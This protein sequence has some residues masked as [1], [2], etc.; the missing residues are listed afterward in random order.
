MRK[1]G[2]TIKAK[3]T[4]VQ[5]VVV[6]P[7][8][9]KEWLTY[10]SR[11]RKVG[12]VYVDQYASDMSKNMWVF[13][14]DAIVFGVKDGE[15]ILL[16]GQKRLLACVKSGSNFRTLVVKGLPDTVQSSIDQGQ[17]RSAAQ[18]FQLLG[19]SQKRH[20][21]ITAVIR[22]IILGNPTTRTGRLKVSTAEC[23][24]FNEAY[25]WVQKWILSEIPS[26]QSTVS[27]K[28]MSSVMVAVIARARQH[29]PDDCDDFVRE[30]YGERDGYFADLKN[31]P[32]NVFARW[33]G[34]VRVAS[35]I[36]FHIEIYEKMQAALHA[37][38]HRRSITKLNRMKGEVFPDFPGFE[39]EG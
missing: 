32:G 6:T 21:H 30:Y 37:S 19:L 17:I 35:G 4:D 5:V 29:H 8:L 7:S 2:A 13:N 14:G 10:N 33:H 26:K 16:D 1:E 36:G 12:Q 34:R 24:R 39:K 27:G 23:M 20:T 28:V 3:G 25:P 18:Q 9:A 31:S 22:A 38:I 11:N 15:V